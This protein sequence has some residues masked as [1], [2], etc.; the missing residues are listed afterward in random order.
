MFDDNL[1]K[2]SKIK[3]LPLNFKH[4]VGSV[5]EVHDV[6]FSW[7]V[8]HLFGEDD[9]F[10]FVI[11]EVNLLEVFHRA[12]YVLKTFGVRSPKMMGSSSAEEN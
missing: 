10:G 3:D 9:L 5:M 11:E 6:I 1:N 8:V 7:D 4:L 12:F 2:H